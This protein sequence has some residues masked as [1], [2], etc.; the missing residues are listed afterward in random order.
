MPSL[1]RT[2]LRHA[3]AALGVLTL[4]VVAM[5]VAALIWFMQRRGRE[6]F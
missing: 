5:M 1:P 3:I 2:L 4:I 6:A